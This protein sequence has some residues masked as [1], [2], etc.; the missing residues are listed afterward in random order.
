MV[1]FVRNRLAAGDFRPVIDR[2]YSLDDVVEAFRYVETGQK[3]GNV[4]IRVS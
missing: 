3:T 2:V 4:V 1:E